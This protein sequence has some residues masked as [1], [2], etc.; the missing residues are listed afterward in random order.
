LLSRLFRGARVGRETVRH[1]RYPGNSFDRQYE[2]FR[3]PFGAY[4][5][6]LAPEDRFRLS[7]CESIVRR[8]LESLRTTTAGM[9]QSRAGG[10]PGA[11]AIPAGGRP[12]A[13]CASDG[14]GH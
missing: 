4:R 11:P 13:L 14:M 12:T 1:L 5:E 9:A 2:K 3:Q 10:G 6:A 7:L 8:R